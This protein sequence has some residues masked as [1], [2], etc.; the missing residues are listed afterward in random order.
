MKDLL[1]EFLKKEELKFSTEKDSDIIQISFSTKETNF[2]AVLHI[3]EKIG[4]VLFYLFGPVNVPEER[5]EDAAEYI[6]KANFGLQIGNLELDFND[7]EIRYKSTLIYE[8]IRPKDATFKR[9]MYPAIFT[10]QRYYQHILPLIYGSLSVDEAI[11]VAE[12]TDTSEK[13]CATDK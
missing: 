6:T 9:F 12:E 8:G 1:S 11:K 3:R 10:M 4:L 13:E 2:Q 5:R 7:G